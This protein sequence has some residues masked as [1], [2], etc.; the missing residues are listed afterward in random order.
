MPRPLFISSDRQKIAGH[1]RELD[2]LR[3]RAAGIWIVVGDTDAPAFENGW[4][5]AGGGFQALRFRWLLG[6]GVELQ[7]S[8]TGGTLGT[9]VFTLPVG[10]R[11]D[12]EIRALA[13]D[14][15]GATVVIRI[16]AAGAVILG[17]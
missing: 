1:R 12:N 4:S 8:V 3:N 7:G 2:R 17:I 14:D 9:T 13:S 11:P 15:T 6:G 10:Y 5:S 16:T